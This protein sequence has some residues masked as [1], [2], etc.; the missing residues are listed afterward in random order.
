M[1]RDDRDKTLGIDLDNSEV[2]AS[3]DDATRIDVD[4]MLQG[5][6]YKCWGPIEDWG[7]IA[8]RKDSE[9]D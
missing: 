9:R 2:D 6:W 1:M 8:S 5:A 4:R 3:I 7:P